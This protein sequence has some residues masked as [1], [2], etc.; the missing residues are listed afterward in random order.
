[1]TQS[2]HSHYFRDVSDLKSVDVYRV[3][4][5]FSVTHPCAQHA[6]KKLLVA[7]NRGGGKSE[8]RDITEARDTLNRWL[9][10]IS[11]TIG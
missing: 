8:V 1:M 11:E 5:L 3:L 2:N 10:M 6:I 7:G 9:E 4:D